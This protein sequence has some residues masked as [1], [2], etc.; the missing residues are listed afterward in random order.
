MQPDLWELYSLMYKSRLFEQAVKKLWNDGKISGEMH[1]AIGEE[2]VAAGIVSHLK[3]GDAMALDHRGTPQML[4]RG[5]DP[6]SLLCELLGKPE[7]LCGGMG[8]H[9]HLFS[10]QHLA[11]SSGIVG[12]SGPA[13]VGFAL[14]A[15]HLRPGAVA[16]AFFGEGAMNQGMMMESMNLAATWKLPVLFVCKDSKIAI[17]T[18][19]SS[20]T[21]GSLFNRAK[22]FNIPAKEID[23]TDVEMIWL[24]AHKAIDEARRGEGPS[25][26]LAHC[27][28]P[29]GHFLGDPLIRI[30]KNPLKEMKDM[31]PALLKS[32]LKPKGAAVRERTESLSSVTS[33]LGQTTKAQFFN[34]N[35]PLDMTRKELKSDKNRLEQLEE[36]IEQEIKQIVINALNG[37]TDNKKAVT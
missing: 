5:V 8:G 32:I 22:S 21:S 30:T 28:R 4:M 34:F 23:G 37:N 29:E 6:V 3:E 36:K 19:S 26:L 13:A 2:A 15:Q 25:F 27:S 9:M 17:T 7:G 1:L 14:A 20:V 16:V 33:I 35:D 11:A 12:S 24:A 31:A 18:V 10:E